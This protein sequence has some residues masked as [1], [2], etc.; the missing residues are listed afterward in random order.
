MKI[1]LIDNM[2]N[3]FFALARYL[4][5]FGLDAELFLIPG[6]VNKHFNPQ[7]DTWR[8]VAELGWVK[9]FPGTYMLR[10]CYRASSV[11]KIQKTFLNYER[12]ISCGL[13]T[14]ILYHAGIK[15]DL[16]I[17]FGADLYNSPFFSRW[18]LDYFS[19]DVV[20]RAAY[21]C[22]MSKLQR[23]G[24]KTAGRIVANSNWKMASD[25][26]DKLGVTSINLPR[27]MVY[28]EPIP[29]RCQRQYA[30]IE[31]H[32][33]VVFS[34]TRHLW[35]SNADPMSDFSLHGGM[36]RNDKLIRAFYRL[37]EKSIYKSPLLIL[38]K[39][40]DDVGASEQLISELKLQDYVVWL[41]LLPRREIVSI[42][43]KSTFVADQ[44]R[45]RMSATSSGTTNEALA[46]GTP[47][48][49][50][51]DGAIADPSDPYFNAPIFDAISE[52]EI[53]KV[54]LD[55]GNAPERYIHV[56]NVQCDWF[57]THCGRGLVKKYIEALD[58]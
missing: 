58:V 33:F 8:D 52:D 28:K 56:K 22:I 14:G 23:S 37:V 13:A 32:D 43:T 30:W 5:D 39:Y 15:T 24:I 51:T 2:N 41:P 45:Q 18:Q 47:V 12:V 6:Q 17:P 40:G 27:I 38:C 44:F 35:K 1:A 55:Y 16:F 20:K 26:L 4:R 42:M 50:N 19:P 7:A 3:N 57:E 49:T 53:V 48:I 10:D 54:F 25:A 46:Y 29:E 9:D 11:K 36:K 21:A 31:R 34:P